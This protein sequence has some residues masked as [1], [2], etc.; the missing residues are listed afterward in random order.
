[1]QIL[2]VTPYYLP[3]LQFGGP[4]RKIHAFARG[5]LQCGHQVKVITFDHASRRN[6]SEKDMDGIAVQYLPWFGRGLWQC[7]VNLPLLRGRIC[8]NEL[9]HCFGLYNLLVP[10]AAR[11]AKKLGKP[12]ISEPLGMYPPRARNRLAKHFYN[13]AITRKLFRLS[14]AVIATSEAEKADLEPLVSKDRLFLRRNGIESRR[15]SDPVGAR[16]LRQQWGVSSAEKVILFMG[17]IS[18]IKN[19][20]QLI[21]AFA[22]AAMPEAKLILA[23]PLAERKYEERLRQIID[24]KGLGHIVILAGPLYDGSQHA[25]LDAADLFV[26]PSLSESFGNAAGE[27]VLAGVPVLLTDTCGIAALIHQRAGL[28]VPLGVESLA[29]GLRKMLEDLEFRDQMTAGRGEVIREL[30]WDE[31]VRQMEELY[32]KIIGNF[33]CGS[34]NRERR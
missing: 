14:A 17:R 22:E 26:L 16:Q 7:P 9:V 18:P 2:F 13:R 15:S 20:E 12:M 11:L 32:G 23:G 25:A 3:D 31:P 33:K 21:L 6:H 4:P 27:A 28:A 5:L 19:L 30:S 24:A 29:A 10:I 8:E 34:R 1:M